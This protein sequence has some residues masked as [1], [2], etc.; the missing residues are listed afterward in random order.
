MLTPFFSC[1][2]GFVAQENAQTVFDLFV[3]A[4]KD[5]PSAAATTPW[6]NS[7]MFQYGGSVLGNRNT[8][9]AAFPVGEESTWLAVTWAGWLNDTDAPA[10]TKWVKAL[11]QAIAPYLEYYYLDGLAY[12]MRSL[13]MAKWTYG[14]NFAKLAELKARYDPTN[15]FRNNLNVPPLVT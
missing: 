10:V 14:K 6:F 9:A 1:L 3:E 15:V 7:V 13:P 5:P 2:G 8:S 12:D 11:H 4:W